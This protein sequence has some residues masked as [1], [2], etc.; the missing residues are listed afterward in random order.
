[1]PNRTPFTWPRC[2]IAFNWLPVTLIQPLVSIS[3]CFPLFSV[4]FSRICRPDMKH[5]RKF[6]A[7]QIA[8]TKFLG[9][10]KM[11]PSMFRLLTSH[12]KEY[13]RWSIRVSSVSKRSPNRCDGIKIFL[14]DSS[15]LRIQQRRIL[16]AHDL[17]FIFCSFYYF[18]SIYY[19]PIL[20]IKWL[21]RSFFI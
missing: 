13:V 2:N 8:L 16:D 12:D 3:H 6:F 14:V 15:I 5:I 1:M 20:E 18:I 11:T 9:V 19:S 10:S 4:R 17:P 7:K 21:Q